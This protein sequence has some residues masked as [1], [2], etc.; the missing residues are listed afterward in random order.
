MYLGKPHV[1]A[2]F[3]RTPF[4]HFEIPTSFGSYLNLSQFYFK[5]DSVSL[6]FN[7]NQKYT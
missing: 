7:T 5:A 2:S 3:V 1:H 4:I 6:Y